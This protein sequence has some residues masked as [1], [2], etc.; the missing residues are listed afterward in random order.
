[1]SNHHPNCSA[2]G[3]RHGEPHEP[4]CKVGRS[5]GFAN[6][7]FDPAIDSLTVSGLI[8][9]AVNFVNDFPNA[10]L[11]DPIQKL[12]I[13][14][15]GIDTDDEMGLSDIA[16][17]EAIEMLKALLSI[18]QDAPTARIKFKAM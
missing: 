2:C 15:S 4:G 13:R 8:Q 12:C 18:C 5:T 16:E 9:E 1:M 10:D 3:S 14:L 11:A 6:V 17:G 7:T